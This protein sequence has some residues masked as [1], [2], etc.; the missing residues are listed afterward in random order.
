MLST[1][2]IKICNVVICRI[3]KK[4]PFN[5]FKIVYPGLKSF[6]PGG[7]RR[8]DMTKP[9]TKV[10]SLHSL[11]HHHICHSDCQEEC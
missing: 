4:Y 5:K 8:S 9:E 3:T 7:K 1:I 6:R 10:S 11:Y 2:R